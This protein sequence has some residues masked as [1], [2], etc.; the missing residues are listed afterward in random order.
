MRARAYWNANL[1]TDNLSGELRVSREAIDE[2]MAYAESPDWRWARR[3]AGKRL[4]GRTLVDLGGGIG[5]HGLLWAREGARVIVVDMAEKRLA[6]LRQ[7]AEAAGLS[8]Q[9]RFVAGSAESMPLAND[10]VDVVFTKSVLI[11]TDL[12]DAAREVRRVLRTGG[13]GVFIEPLTGNP[14]IRLYRT[15]LAPGEWKSITRYFDD[16]AIAEL[17]EPFGA[18]RTHAFYLLGAAAFA[19]QY[20]WRHM[21]LWRWTMRAF[22]RL[23]RAAMRLAPGLRHWCWFC[24]LCVRKR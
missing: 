4:E 21:G 18:V 14:L 9:M 13:R 11:H 23:D 8:D 16:A 20:G 17:S 7:I 1:D 10:S 2:G 3:R 24:G 15:W 12:P 22:G 6:A 19:F 5:M